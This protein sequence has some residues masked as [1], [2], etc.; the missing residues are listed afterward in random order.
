MSKYKVLKKQI[1]L[2]GFL[3]SFT[4]GPAQSDKRRI[5][6]GADQTDRYFHAL[7]G[8]RVAIVANPTSQIAGVPLVDSL[9]HAGVRVIKV[10]GPE[11]GFRGDASA[12]VTVG[13]G[14]AV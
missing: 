13:G 6:T 9:L 8:K 14:V 3:L 11:H 2:F 10:F 12:G 1:L 4:Y 7:R 5:M